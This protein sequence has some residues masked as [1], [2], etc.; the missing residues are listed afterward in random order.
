MHFG[1][2]FID[3]ACSTNQHLYE[4]QDCRY[5]DMQHSK[6]L[7]VNLCFCQLF[8]CFQSVCGLTVSPFHFLSSYSMCAPS[9][10]SLCQILPSF[11]FYP[12]VFSDSF[13]SR[14]LYSPSH[15]SRKE[16]EREYTSRKLLSHTVQEGD[17]MLKIKQCSL[18]PQ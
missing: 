3:R 17:S 4:A 1:C 16:K 15:L 12:S 2:W 5:A 10:L 14:L 13:I 8:L 6:A 11:L 18:A 9:F 7:P